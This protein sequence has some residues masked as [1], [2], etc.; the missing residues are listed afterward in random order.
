MR[1]RDLFSKTNIEK[2]ARLDT[3]SQA[4][5][6]LG[7]GIFSLI[8][9][10]A[11]IVFLSVSLEDSLRGLGFFF[12]PVLWLLISIIMIIISII[13]Y[14][15]ARQEEYEKK[16]FNEK[17]LQSNISDVDKLNGSS[18]ELFCKV[19]F[20][21][22]GYSVSTTKASGDYGV[23][24]I[25]TK[26]NFRS[27]GQCKRYSD[28]VPISA[29][30]EIVAAKNFYN[31]NDTFII[32][33]SYFTQ[34]AKNLAASN[35]VKLIDRNKLIDLICQVKGEKPTSLLQEVP[36]VQP[37]PQTLKPKNDFI[38][39]NN[40]NN[41]FAS[42]VHKIENDIVVAYSKQDLDLVKALI[43][44]V[45]EKA[46]TNF[47]S[48]KGISLHFFY[49]N[50]CNILYSMRHINEN[51]I[52][53]CLTFCNKDIELIKKINFGKNITITTITRKAI[54]LEKE[55]KINEAISL[56]ELAISKDYLDNGKPFSIRK[57]RLQ[58]KLK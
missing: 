39:V 1:T 27:I 49:Q 53:E 55:N 58:N 14:S 54:I 33:N 22:L 17:L 2:F 16:I 48:Q 44:K 15:C 51:L 24:L 18:F 11:L 43:L 38:K 35:S 12:L 56:C 26:D 52:N 28:K 36:V 25:M 34:P 40:D 32:T 3:K 13:K 47:N 29:V 31:C 57:A 50:I 6:L 41:N 20:E 23:D 21:K 10:I 45:E 7:I 8:F 9:S 30:Q 37:T 42:F 46:N 5:R 4:N 19:L